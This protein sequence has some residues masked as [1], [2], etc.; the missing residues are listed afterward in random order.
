[1]QQTNKFMEKLHPPRGGFLGAL[2]WMNAWWSITSFCLPTNWPFD[3]YSELCDG[4]IDS[5]PNIRLTQMWVIYE[6]PLWNTATTFDSNTENGNC[7]RLYS[8]ID[9]WMNF[10]KTPSDSTSKNWMKTTWQSEKMLI[11]PHQ[12]AANYHRLT[13]CTGR[14]SRHSVLVCYILSRFGHGERVV[15]AL[16]QPLHRVHCVEC[17]NTVLFCCVDWTCAQKADVS[18]ICCVLVISKMHDG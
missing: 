4:Q 16:F 8:R 9:R 1:M 13:F 10:E 5:C 17:D 15:E 6:L 12:T 11:W 18:T 14:W 2:A 3:S 7:S